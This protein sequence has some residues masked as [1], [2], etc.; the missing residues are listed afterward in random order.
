MNRYNYTTQGLN[1]GKFDGYVVSYPKSGRTWVRLFIFKYFSIIESRDLTFNTS[2]FN[3]MPNLYFTH[4][5]WENKIAWSLWDRIRGKGIVPKGEENIK[6]LI[7]IARDPRDVVV[8]LFFH[9]QKRLK[10][11][12]ALAMSLS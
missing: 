4:D 11:K 1:K 6:P 10:N 12:R 8:S 9:M 5:I 2:H 7:L 3:R